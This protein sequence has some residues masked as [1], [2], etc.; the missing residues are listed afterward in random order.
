MSVF[1]LTLAA[2]ERSARTAIGTLCLTYRERRKADL[3]LAD[4]D[5]S[6]TLAM[7]P[8]NEMTNKKSL[9]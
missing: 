2:S 5:G 8:I 3:L 6:T 9:N 1:A 7:A 4:R